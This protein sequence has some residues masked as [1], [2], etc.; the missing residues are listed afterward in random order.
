MLLV[1][2]AEYGAI[3]H[4]VKTGDMEKL[5]MLLSGFFLKTLEKAMPTP[6][7]AKRIV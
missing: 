6:A 7:V 3:E 1:Y 2:K 5:K 4:A